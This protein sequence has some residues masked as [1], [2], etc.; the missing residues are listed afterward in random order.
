MLIAVA[1]LPT[2][3]PGPPTAAL[4]ISHNHLFGESS[5]QSRMGMADTV[6]QEVATAVQDG[7]RS[8]EHRMQA[9]WGTVAGCLLASMHC[10]PDSR[11]GLQHCRQAG[12][13][14]DRFL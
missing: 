11:C 10:C 12:A 14:V 1:G 5:E 2:V 7:V 9:S 8:F 6:R 13:T 3:A 4:S